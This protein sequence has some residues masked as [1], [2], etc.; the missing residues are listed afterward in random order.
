MATL[1]RDAKVRA[2]SDLRYE[3]SEKRVRARLGDR[4]VADSAHPILVWEPRRVLPSYAGPAA[5]LSVELAS[6]A[7]S[8]PEVHQTPDDAI[9][10]G[11]IPF[12]VHSTE[13][14]V[15]DVRV[16]GAT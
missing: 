8:S 14:E 9:L 16:D 13:G 1:L 7:L 5:D 6:S 15:L 10:H 3:P 4:V 12:A 11:G 2:L